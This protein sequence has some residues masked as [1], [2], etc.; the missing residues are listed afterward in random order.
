[1]K[2]C[3]IVDDSPIVRRVAR[4]LLTGLGFACREAED[5]EK[6]LESCNASMPDILLLDWN[7]PVMDGITCLRQLR[8]TPAAANTKVIICTTQA[9]IE[10]IEEALAAGADEYIMKPFDREMLEG[11]FRQVGVL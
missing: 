9:A 11:K 7:M 3:L 1:M 8:A 4:E 5:G 6:A 10:E 2:N